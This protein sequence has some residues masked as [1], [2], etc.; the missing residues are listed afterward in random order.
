MA[1]RIVALLFVISINSCHRRPILEP[2]PSR[3]TYCWW[4]SQ[5]VTQ[6]SVLVA[7]AFQNALS[8]AGFSKAHWSRNADS[9][10]V[11]AGPTH[12]HA[13]PAGAMYGF[14]V[15][16]FSARDS[17]RCAWRGMPTADLVRRPIGAESCFHTNV[18]IYRSSN[19]STDAD[20]VAADYVL[21]LCGDVYKSA[22]ALLQH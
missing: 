17:V 7:W 10:W 2:V 22:M 18:L 21:P 5:Y 15:V 9:A 14:R 1:K 4:A 6:P 11:T 3:Q 13:T 19:G 12:L 16:A 8:M 20:S